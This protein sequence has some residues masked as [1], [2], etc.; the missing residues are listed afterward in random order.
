MAIGSEHIEETGAIRD[1]LTKTGLP[2]SDISE[3][4]TSPS[5]ISK[6]MDTWLLGASGSRQMAKPL[7]FAHLL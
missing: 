5:S 6:A 2:A 1:L 4:T 3:T 7:C